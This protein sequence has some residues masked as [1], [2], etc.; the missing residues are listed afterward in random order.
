MKNKKLK[1]LLEE[2]DPRKSMDLVEDR[3]NEAL[4]EFQKKDFNSYDEFEELMGEFVCLA[5]Q[6]INDIIYP[7]CDF[8]DYYVGRAIIYFDQIFPVHGMIAAHRIAESGA[9]GGI[10]P[11]LTQ[12]A[13]HIADYE[14]K[15]NIEFPVVV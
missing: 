11:L 12:L 10:R 8:R 9:E 2:I 14:I 3:V 5:D 6:K 7:Y 1:A 4:N 13:Q 15:R